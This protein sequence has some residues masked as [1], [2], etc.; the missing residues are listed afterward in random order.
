MNIFI[1]EHSPAIRQRLIAFT[2]HYDTT[3]VA[4]SAD[5]AEEALSAILALRPD[6]AIVDLHLAA[7]CGIDCI[8]RL[9]GAG[10]DIPIVAVS[11]TPC[12]S[13]RR[14]AIES[15]ADG[16]FDKHRQLAGAFHRLRALDAERRHLREDSSWAS[17]SPLA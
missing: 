13:S 5:S 4:G 7:G 17:W 10:I 16:V 6:A 3:C 15:G 8:R 14:H 9:R 11:D 1:V 12:D 2:D